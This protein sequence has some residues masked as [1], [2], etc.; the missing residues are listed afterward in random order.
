MEKIRKELKEYEAVVM[1]VNPFAN[2]QVCCG[3]VDA[4]EIDETTMES[5]IWSGALSGRGDPG[6]GWYLRWLQS[7]VCLVQRHDRR[8]MCSMEMEMQTEPKRSWG[9]AIQERTLGKECREEK[10]RKKRK[11]NMEKNK[12][13]GT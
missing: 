9:K 1:S 2:A 4:N 5:K 8:K 6:C 3:G 7:S 13:T 12:K 10:Y 11:K